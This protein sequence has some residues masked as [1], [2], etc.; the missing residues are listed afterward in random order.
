MSEFDLHSTGLFDRIP[1]APVRPGDGF[2]DVHAHLIH[3]KFEGIE[4]E[5]ADECIQ[6][7][8]DFV[9][10]NGLEPV[11]NRKIL[12][13]C[14]N[15]PLRMLPALGIYPLEAANQFIYT[16]EDVATMAEQGIS[17]L[18]QVNWEH[19]FPR[20]SRFS[21]D[22]EIDFIER[23]IQE[24]RIIA[25]GECGLDKYYLTDDVS[26]TE[27]ERVLRKLMKLGVKYDIPLILHTRKA[28][29][30]VFDMLLE[31]NVKKADFHCFGGKVKLGV[32]IANAGYYLSI[33]SAVANSD[34][35]QSFKKLAQA[36]PLNRILTETDSPYMGPVKGQDN[37]PVTVLQAVETIAKLK[38]K[39]ADEMKEIIRT[40]F[41]DLFGI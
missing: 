41:H 38:N 16:K 21:V 10:V 9:V 26:F 3:E 28:E 4:N 17:E 22:D 11:S 31:E 29:K 5:I 2:V 1:K 19:E 14:E 6:N 18:P 23:M 40:N 15:Y 37:R 33:P 7:G 25:I 24:N 30:R 12:S 39:S 13:F 8:M 36:L 27:Q 34:Q 20:P 32:E 35:N